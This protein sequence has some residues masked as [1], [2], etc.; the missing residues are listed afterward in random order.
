M[1]HSRV[2]SL[3][4]EKLRLEE[5]GVFYCPFHRHKIYLKTSPLYGK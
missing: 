1:P 3:E 4:I 5:D 2:D